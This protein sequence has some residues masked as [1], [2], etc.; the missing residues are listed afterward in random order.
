MMPRTGC[1]LLVIC[2]VLGSVAVTDARSYVSSKCSSK[3]WNKCVPDN[4]K[5]RANFSHNILCFCISC[6]IGSP[7]GYTC[8]PFSAYGGTPPPAQWFALRGV[9]VG[10]LSSQTLEAINSFSL[11]VLALTDAG[12]STIENNAFARFPHLRSLHLDCNTL[13]QLEHAFFSGL[14]TSPKSTAYMSF[15]YNRISRLETGCFEEIHLTKLDLS[16][17]LLSEVASGWLRG[18]VF[19]HTLLLGHNKIEVIPA[20]ALDSLYDLRVLNLSHNPLTC[21]SQRTLSGLSLQTFSV[22]RERS[23]ISWEKDNKMDWSLNV[24]KTDS[25]N[26]E[27]KIYLR[28]DNLG[29]CLTYSTTMKDFQLKW[30]LV[31]AITG[32]DGKQEPGCSSFAFGPLDLRLPFVVATAMKKPETNWHLGSCNLCPEAWTRHGGTAIGLKEG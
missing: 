12:I 23:V 7:E 2:S 18:L 3:H 22:G 15:S 24:D 28:I 20:N 1:W 10:S 27:Q 4:I 31:G 32:F 13:S 19:L 11:T 25:P 29:F 6:G 17:N 9:F 26:R 5:V 8:A 21:L 30:G 14:N 16:H